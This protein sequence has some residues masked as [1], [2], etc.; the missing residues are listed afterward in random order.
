MTLPPGA[1]RCLSVLDCQLPS[2]LPALA[3]LGMGQAVLDA[4]GR[5]SHGRQRDTLTDAAWHILYG[6]SPMEVH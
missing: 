6:I 1:R 3:N 5:L 4:C 2:P